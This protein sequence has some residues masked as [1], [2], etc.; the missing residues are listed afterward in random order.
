MELRTFLIRS[1]PKYLGCIRK[2]DIKQICFFRRIPFAFAGLGSLT[3]GWLG[4]ALIRRGITLD[5]SRKIAL[6]ISASLMPASL[7]IVASP[8]GFAIV[9]FSMAMFAHQFWS[10]NIQT[11]PADLFPSK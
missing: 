11:L 9:F 1:S 3:G 5:R 6:A 8:L 10:A 7:F 4:A 2:I